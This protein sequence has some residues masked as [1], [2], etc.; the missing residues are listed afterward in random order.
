MRQV[1]RGRE[2]RGEEGFAVKRIKKTEPKPDGTANTVKMKR[3]ELV[4]ETKDKARN[5]KRATENTGAICI[6][7]GK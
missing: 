1:V 3:K 6:V 5:I 2:I 4:K 7:C